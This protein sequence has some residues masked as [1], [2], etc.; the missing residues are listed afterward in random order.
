MTRSPIFPALFGALLLAAAPAAAQETPA[1]PAAEKAPAPTEAA[2]AVPAPDAPAGQAAGTPAPEAAP[3]PA[4]P[5]AAA[6]EASG[7]SAR[8]RE[9]LVMEGTPRPLTLREAVQMA[10][11]NAEEIEVVRID[12]RKAIEDAR[13]QLGAFNPVFS[14]SYNYTN[15]D[16]ISPNAFN[17]TNPIVKTKTHNFTLGLGGLIPTGATYDIALINERLKNES[18]FSTLIPQYTVKLQGTIKQPL[19]KDAGLGVT[20]TQ[21]RIARSLE[22]ARKADLL[23]RTQQTVNTVIQSYWELFFRQKDLEAKQDSLKAAEDLVRVAENRVR[24]KVDPPINLTQARAGAETRREQ[25]ILAREQLEIA[26]DNLKRLLMTV[27]TS[28]DLTE[29]VLLEPADSPSYEP[30]DPPYRASVTTATEKRPEF[31]SLRIARENAARVSDAAWMG[32]LPE[33]NATATAGVAGLAGSVSPLTTA[34]P[35]QQAQLEDRFG[36]GFGSAY[37]SAADFDGPYFSLGAEFRMPVP[38]QKNRAAYARAKLDEENADVALRQ[39]EETVFIDV[40][41]AIRSLQTGVQRIK[42]TGLNVELAKENV[43]AEKRRYEVGLS[44]SW[45]LLERE[46]ELTEARAAHYRALTDYNN[47][48]AAYELSTG[49]ILDYVGVDLVEEPS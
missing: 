42:S 13:E 36:G 28:R 20:L 41:K 43:A 2:P 8:P 19:L 30:F 44:T 32:R 5:A 9:P 27:D 31:T 49:T 22:E 48:R 17:V 11:E 37:G 33:L 21:L 14:A 3:A 34:T 35:A 38:N 47:A 16:T 15:S 39:L 45:D 7:G 1:A 23:Q 4:A 29:P 40:R 10:L 46:K 18:R 12:Y 26:R 24:V 6:P 25:V